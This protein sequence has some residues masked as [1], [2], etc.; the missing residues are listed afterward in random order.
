MEYFV[1]AKIGIRKKGKKHFVKFLVVFHL[2]IGVP[3]TNSD[4]FEILAACR[5]GVYQFVETIERWSQ[6]LA[7]W[8]VYAEHLQPHSRAGDAAQRLLLFLKAQVFPMFL[9][10]FSEKKDIFD[11]V[12]RFQGGGPDIFC[13]CGW[14]QQGYEENK[15]KKHLYS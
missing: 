14:R 3:G 15:G 9:V 2:V 6:F 7:L 4:H 5:I 13:M 12:V 10:D 8:A 1:D 11:I